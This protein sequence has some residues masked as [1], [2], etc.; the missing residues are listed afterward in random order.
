M[1]I[2]YFKYPMATQPIIVCVTVLEPLTEIFS[3]VELPT[4]LPASLVILARSSRQVRYYE[5]SRRKSC[6]LL[7]K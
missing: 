4:R 2:S 5:K 7:E 3:V 1:A 6:D